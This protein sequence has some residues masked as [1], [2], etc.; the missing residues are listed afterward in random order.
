MSMAGLLTR[1]RFLRRQL[2]VPLA[3]A[4]H[5]NGASHVRPRGRDS[6]AFEHSRHDVV[7][8]GKRLALLFTVAGNRAVGG[9]DAL[10]PD[11]AIRCRVFVGSSSSGAVY[12]A[13]VLLI[14]RLIF[15]R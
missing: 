15:C 12:S 9:S 10:V 5:S 7:D 8:L 2:F 1:S 6:E 14:L 13:S 3:I 4:S 11:R